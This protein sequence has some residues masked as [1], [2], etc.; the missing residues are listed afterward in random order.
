MMT[1]VVRKV[2]RSLE[3]FLIHDCKQNIAPFS[4][5]EGNRL[6]S[7]MIQCTKWMNKNELQTFYKFILNTYKIRD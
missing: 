1:S 7:P 5:E 3:N 2:L 4:H 6:R